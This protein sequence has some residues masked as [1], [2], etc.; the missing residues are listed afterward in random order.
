M[1]LCDCCPPNKEEELDIV[2]IP[3][4]YR[5]SNNFCGDIN[6]VNY[7]KDRRYISMS[8][9]DCF[10]DLDPLKDTMQDRVCQRCSNKNEEFW[11]SIIKLL[12]D[13]YSEV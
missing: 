11:N 7:S 13:S 4:D 1:N 3:I 12:E 6:F 8:C 2:T 10:K 9:R 5:S